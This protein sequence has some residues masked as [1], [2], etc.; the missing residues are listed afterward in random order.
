MDERDEMTKRW[1]DRYKESTTDQLINQAT[2]IWCGDPRIDCLLTELAKRLQ[3]A[4]TV[5]DS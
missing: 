1:K 4:I 2:S 3:R 5:P